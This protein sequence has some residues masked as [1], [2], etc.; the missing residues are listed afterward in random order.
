MG[1]SENY[2]PVSLTCIACKVME[3]IIKND[4]TEHLSEYNV[5]NNSQHGFTKGRACLTNLLEFLEEVYEKLDEGRA[6]DMIYL[7]LAKAFYKVPHIRLAK[8]ME[9]CGFG[10]N[11]LRWIENWLKDRRQRVGIRGAF[12]EWIDVISGV[13]QWSVLEPLLFRIFINDIDTGILSKISKFAD[14]TKLCKDVV[15]EEDAFIIREDLR[16]LYEWAKDWQMLFN[17]GKCSAMHMGKGNKKFKYNIGGVTLRASEEERDLGV[18]MHCS[19]KPSRQ[20]VEAAKR[21]NR[22]LG[23]IKRTIVSR[24]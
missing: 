12:S 15:T 4:M 19:A 17:V 24:E 16:R 8:K 14:D 23:M 21:A 11:L 3:R 9:A 1:E 18:I 13:P 2:R 20:C 10:G 6:V 7:D 22:I 5:I